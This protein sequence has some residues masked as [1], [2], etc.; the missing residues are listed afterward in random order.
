MS[1]SSVGFLLPRLRLDVLYF[2]S[3]HPGPTLGA[4]IGGLA[5]AM[6]LHR[7]GVPF[8]LYE[9]AKQYSVVG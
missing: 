7:K 3:T 2:M 6:A 9:E 5:L 1:P 8:S 4:G